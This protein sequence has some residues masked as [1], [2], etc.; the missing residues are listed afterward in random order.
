MSAE[1]GDLVGG[2][3]LLAEPVGQGGMGRV[4]RGH[5][6]LLDRVVAV[7]EVLLPPQS[8][9][10]HADMVARTLREAR[11]VARLDH[12]GVVTIYDV[13]EHDSAPWIVMQFVSGATLGAA[14]AAEGR[15][16]WERAARIGAQVADA[17]A[18]AHAAGI[19]H[20]DLKPDNILLSGDRAVVTDF[21]IARI[22]DATTRLT[23]TGTRVGTAHYMAPEQLE[24]AAAGPAADMWAL[25]GTLYATVEGTPPFGGPT[26][27]AII[28]AILTRDPAAPE[29]AGPL[30][31]LIASLLAKDPSLRPAASDVSRELASDRSLPRSGGAAPAKT[32]RPSRESPVPDTASQ[33]PATTAAPGPLAGTASATPTETMTRPSSDAAR[34]S[35]PDPAPSSPDNSDQPAVTGT[36]PPR[37][38]LRAVL[39]AAAVAV[40]AAAGITGWLASS[41]SGGTLPRPLA[42]TAAQA[43]L[44]GDAATGAAENSGLSSVACP[45]TGT[46][47]AVGSYAPA[48]GAA[49]K[50]VIETLSNGAWTASNKVAG[51]ALSGLTEV[52]CPMPGSCAA[53]GTYDTGQK[54]SPVAATLSNGTWTAVT[55]PL[56]QGAVRAQSYVYTLECPGEGACLALGYYTSQKGGVYPLAEVLSGA[57]WTAAT[58]PLPQGAVETKGYFSDFSGLA[59]P[60]Q[61]T[62]IAVGQYSDQKGVTHGVIDTLSGGTWT[63]QAGPASSAL[64]SEVV[65]PAVGSCVAVGQYSKG[66]GAYAAMADVLSNGTWAEAAVPLPSDV[67]ETGQISALDQ[68]TCPAQ[69]NCVAVGFDVN[70][71]GQARYL[72]ETLSGGTWT[73]AA[74]PLPSN[75]GTSQKPNPQQGYITELTSVVCPA[76]GYCVTPGSYSP[77]SSSD[78][79]AASIDTLSGTTW[80]AAEAP[81]PADGN[82]TEPTV[83]LYETAC[84]ALGRCIVVGMYTAQDGSY[85]PLIE[86]GTTAHG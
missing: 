38:R 48:S 37:L 58:L 77:V 28:T 16:G 54:S 82:T 10:E 65:C 3:Y 62:C 78:D 51:A 8:P 47:V 17:L 1:A 5:D 13:V 73:L 27:T 25:G 59:C 22:V 40:L 76:A 32:E 18:H 26:L 85:H 66:G 44:P 60:A 19:V 56:P 72:A 64:L 12:P 30:A 6:Q 61:G 81:L 79:G 86:T 11:A 36:R 67:A 34:S 23:S 50:P 33:P 46:C 2:R 55:L 9:Q 57:T 7:K 24:G 21:G 20:R 35:T 75:A 42:W 84:P 14:I 41:G 74:P 39:A 53:I 15:L 52:S 49:P 45:T 83:E 29:H 69:G 71:S 70:R 80:T 31:D 68:I 4:W 43:A 63:A